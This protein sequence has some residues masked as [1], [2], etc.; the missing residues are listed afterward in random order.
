M[1]RTNVLEAGVRF[2]GSVKSEPGFLAV[3]VDYFSVLLY[4]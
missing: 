1:S 2:L 4:W 3:L